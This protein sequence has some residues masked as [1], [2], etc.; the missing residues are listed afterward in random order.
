MRLIGLAGAAGAGK[1]SVALVLQRHGWY[2]FSFSDELYRQIADAFQVGMDLL[3]D[4]RYK[5]TPSALLAPRRCGNPEAR[6]L[7]AKLAG[8]KG[9]A[10][11]PRWVLQR[12]GTDYRRNLYGQDYWVRRADEAYHAATR[13]GR[14]RGAA[15]TSVRFPNELEWVDSLGGEVVHVIRPG[16]APQSGYVSESPLPYRTGD[17]IVSNDSDLQGLEHVVATY[18]LR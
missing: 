4:R 14:Y 3:R 11:S 18:L 5:E 17:A 13:S 6:A 8:N 2:V 16:Y 7:L 10:C 12:W 9:R 15:N 1:D